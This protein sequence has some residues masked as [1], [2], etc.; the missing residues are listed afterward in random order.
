MKR[1][2]M[3]LL[4]DNPFKYLGHIDTHTYLRNGNCK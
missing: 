4:Y 2:E 3:K 1:N